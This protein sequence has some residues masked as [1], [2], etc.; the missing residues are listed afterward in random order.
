MP[1][2]NELLR[3]A[4]TRNKTNRVRNGYE[5]K[6]VQALPSDLNITRVYCGVSHTGPYS[7]SQG[8]VE[9][10]V[11]TYE[12]ALTIARKPELKP[13]A[14]SH[15]TMKRAEQAFIPTVTFYPQ[16]LVRES[17]HSKHNVREIYPLIFQ[18][19]PAPGEQ[20]KRGVAKVYLEWFTRIEKGIFANV[21]TF[22]RHHGCA[23]EMQDPMQQCGNKPM[24]RPLGMPQG[25]E[26]RVKLELSSIPFITVYWD[27]DDEPYFGQE[28]EVQKN[29]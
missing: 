10:E 9:I 2:K 16:E 23:Y 5:T 18:M 20:G 15:V 26:R 1:R 24:Y 8:Q 21:R 14:M 19:M 6:I 28:L 3:E 11:E 29:V 4:I 27:A 13:V 7:S 22:I 12:D 25:T 17:W